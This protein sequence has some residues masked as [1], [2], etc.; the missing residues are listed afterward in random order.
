MDERENLNATHLEVFKR[1]FHV[2]HHDVS[3]SRSCCKLKESVVEEIDCNSFGRM[4]VHFSERWLE[5]FDQP[6]T[7][8]KHTSSIY[9]VQRVSVAIQRGN[10]AAV[11]GCTGGVN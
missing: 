6:L 10:A 11:V 7:T 5:E 2:S 8:T 9:L 3:E 4:H 1:S